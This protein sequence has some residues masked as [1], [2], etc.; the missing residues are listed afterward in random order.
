MEC[1][2]QVSGLT[3]N[4]GC[5]ITR[6][7]AK[8]KWCLLIQQWWYQ[9]EVQLMKLQLKCYWT[10]SK[11]LNESSWSLSNLWRYFISYEKSS[12][13]ILSR[14]SHFSQKSLFIFDIPHKSQIISNIFPVTRFVPLTSILSNQ[15]IVCERRR[16]A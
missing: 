15:G 11:S 14:C 16:G 13:I 8:E 12:S 4:R 2:A 5:K 10:A 9:T 7:L 6:R 3:W 1:R